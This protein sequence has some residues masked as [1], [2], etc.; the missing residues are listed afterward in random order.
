M[1]G[2]CCLGFCS[3]RPR[4]WPLISGPEW[5]SHA[6]C[7][8]VMQAGMKYQAG[9]RG[10]VT[11]L[12]CATAGAQEHAASRVILGVMNL[13]RQHDCEETKEQRNLM[14]DV[15]G[16]VGSITLTGSACSHLKFYHAFLVSVW[17]CQVKSPIR[18]LGP[19]GLSGLS[20]P[21]GPSG[22]SGPSGPSG[23]PGQVPKP[24]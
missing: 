9:Q 14:P 1:P 24:S 20:G 19:S 18:P 3:P 6:T 11:L 23:L 4:A 21:S 2:H 17:V 13:V 8:S 10:D 12:F 22:V 7:R 16:R 15:E 5:N